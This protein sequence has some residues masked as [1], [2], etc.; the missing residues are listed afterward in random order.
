MTRYTNLHEM[1]ILF[2]YVSCLQNVVIS[3]SRRSTIRIGNLD[4]TFKILR[5][6]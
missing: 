4:S 3:Q 1:H 6:A 2:I 5:T